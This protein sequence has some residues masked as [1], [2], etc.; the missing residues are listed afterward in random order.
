[1][2]RAVQI[3]GNLKLILMRNKNSLWSTFLKVPAWVWLLLSLSIAG[4]TYLSDAR[5]QRVRAQR[6]ALINADADR[7][8]ADLN[9]TDKKIRALE[10]KTMWTKADDAAV[11][12][13]KA[14]LKALQLRV[15]TLKQRRSEIGKR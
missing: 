2:S 6:I 7:L 5:E 13:V 10:K 9:R 4:W 8:E 3:C 14:Q 11:R 12:D 1:M 15:Q